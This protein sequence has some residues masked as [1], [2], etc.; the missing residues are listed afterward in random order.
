ML[1][2]PGAHKV[3]FVHSESL[4]PQS[5]GCSV[6]KSH[7]PPKSN[8]LG[9]LSS[10]AGSQVGKSAVGPRG[11]LTVRDF[12]WYNCSAVRGSFAWLALWCPT[13]NAEEAEVEWFHDDL[14]DLVELTPQKDV[15]FIIG[16]WNAIVRSQEISEVIGKF[17]LEVQNETGKRLMEFCQKNALV[18]A[19][20]LFQ[21]H[22]R[23]PYTWTSLDGQ[24]Q[25]H[26]DYILCSWRRRCSIQSTE[27]RPRADYGSDHEFFIPN[28]DLNWR[29]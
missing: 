29:K 20:T 13:T 9:I 7:W 11:F 17:G 27:T 28:S 8:F 3:L 22:M 6:I 21:Q 26:T 1:L 4:F 10:F 15:L 25:N 2:A 18:I 12:H 14:Q 24:Y 5:C 16:H 19:N 23:W